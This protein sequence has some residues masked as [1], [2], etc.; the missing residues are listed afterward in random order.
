MYAFL[1]NLS[2]YFKCMHFLLKLKV[3]KISQIYAFYENFERVQSAGAKKELLLLSEKF[4]N[5]FE[6]PINYIISYC[7]P[8]P[9]SGGVHTIF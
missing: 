7:G 3:Y 8:D 5:F 9:P 1:V 6:Y 4:N 2:L